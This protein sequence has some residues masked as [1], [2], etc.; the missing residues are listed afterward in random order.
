MT[1]SWHFL[2]VSF[3]THSWLS[4]DSFV[5]HSWLGLLPQIIHELLGW[6]AERYLQGQGILWVFTPPYI[7]SHE[8][9]LPIDTDINPVTNS[10]HF[11]YFAKTRHPM[12]FRHLIW[13]YMPSHELHI[14]QH[15][16]HYLQG[17]LKTHSW[18]IRNSIVT[19]FVWLTRDSTSHELH[20]FIN[21]SATTYRAHS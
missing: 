16:R 19:H 1:Y 12:C 10:T 3:V 18:L 14:N 6:F 7:P 5:T 15:I 11:H 2:C 9:H 21:T 4:R 8:P 13:G 20:V 17:S